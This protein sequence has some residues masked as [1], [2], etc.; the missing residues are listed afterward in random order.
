MSKLKRVLLCL[1]L[2]VSLACICTSCGDSEDTDNSNIGDN[3]SNNDSSDQSQNNGI[4]T[5]IFL[6][7]PVTDNLSVSGEKDWFR[8]EVQTNGYI[9]IEFTHDTV[10]STKNHWCMDIFMSDATTGYGR[11][12]G[13]TY[14]DVVGNEN[15]TT[16]LMG[17]EAGTYYIKIQRSSSAYSDANYDIK[18]NYTASPD[19]ETEVNNKYNHANNI[20]LYENKNGSIINNDDVDWYVLNAN[21]SLTLTFT[22]ANTDSTKT[23]WKVTI[24]SSDGVTEIG[25]VDV[26]GNQESAICSFNASGTVYIKVTDN[27]NFRSTSY[28]LNVS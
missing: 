6:N 24:Y 18:I 16:P 13:R 10:A 25:K 8:F 4:G 22:H 15:F 5:E 7:T 2:I 28:V 17:V 23:C 20:S 27:Y 19:W 21:G 14:W 3:S 26:Y 9:E 12:S 11:T 1:L